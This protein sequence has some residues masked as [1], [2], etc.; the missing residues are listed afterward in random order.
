MIN[1]SCN[2]IKFIGHNIFRD[3]KKLKYV[4]LRENP[5]INLLYVSQHF[6]EL[7]YQPGIYNLDEFNEILNRIFQSTPRVLLD[8]Q[9]AIK[10]EK[11]KDFKIKIGSNEFKV[12]KF[13][14]IARSSS[15]AEMILENKNFDELSIEDIEVEVFK[16]ILDFI[17]ED[18][19]PENFDENSL[20]IFEAAGKLK[21]ET[22][23][24]EVGNLLINSVNPQNSFE[25]LKLASE[26][27]HEELKRKSFNEL[28]KYLHEEELSD[29]I[30][31]NFE[32]LKKLVETK[33]E[34]DDK[35]MKMKRE[36]EKFIV[37][38]GN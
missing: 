16:I 19:I 29:E 14:L 20:K 26:F 3:L 32:L 6:D 37:H 12:H 2:K 33:I 5:A 25:I 21:L 18:K 28:K 30:M 31:D 27:D 38:E 7:D 9:S 34:Y 1:F 22:L 8:L 35:M 23:K 15:F 24:T 36:I 11:F 4:D 17:Y 13:L 10:N